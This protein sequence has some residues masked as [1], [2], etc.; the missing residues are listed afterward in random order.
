MTDRLDNLTIEAQTLPLNKLAVV[1]DREPAECK[2]RAEIN[3]NTR[4]VLPDG[5]KMRVSDRFWLSFSS[6]YGLSQNVFNYYHPEE[7]F[8][9]ITQTK[10]DTVRVT[11]EESQIPE[12]DGCLLSATNP[13]K[14][15][16]R[17]D[18][19]RGLV[20]SFGGKGLS[21]ANGIVTCRFDCP[22]PM[23]FEIGG[24][25]FR[26]QFHMEMPLDGYGLPSAY[27]ALLRLVCENGMVGIAPAFKT[28]FQLGSNETDLDPVLRRAFETYNNEEGYHSFRQR[29]ESSTRSWASLHEALS[30]RKAL[31]R[32]TTGQLNAESP[33]NEML[34]RFDAL[35]GD[36][37]SFYGLSA[38]EEL[39]TRKARS[40]PVK[41]TVYDLFN[42]A[43]EASTH[44]LHRRVAKDRVNAWVGQKVVGEYDLENSMDMFAE[45]KDY[46][47]SRGAENPADVDPQA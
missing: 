33:S 34:E 19:A 4:V 30:L 38:R 22:F 8:D 26:T 16:L 3:L 25:G 31:S 37:L 35:C 40:I 2:S 12:M 17:V 32:A 7:V 9:R 42:F 29:V 14:P 20:D 44:H 28:T 43:S 36:P 41:T 24:D 46:F 1:F 18:Q 47:L 21:Y 39:S 6:L 10:Q 5:R 15:L 11:F 27:L 45:Y 23:E 13:A